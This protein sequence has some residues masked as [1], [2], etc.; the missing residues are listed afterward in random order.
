METAFNGLQARLQSITRN[1]IRLDPG[2]YS[3]Y[4]QQIGDALT[5]GIRRRLAGQP[6]NLAEHIRTSVPELR[7]TEQQFQRFAQ[8]IRQSFGDI[9]R[10]SGLTQTE[11]Q[12]KNLLNQY[13]Q[14]QRLQRQVSGTRAPVT[15]RGGERVW[16]SAELRSA[17]QQAGVSLP[18]GALGRGTAR[19]VGLAAVDARMREVAS[20]LER[21]GQQYTRS[22]GGSGRG[23]STAQTSSVERSGERLA[24]TL[25]KISDR[26]N[27]VL[28]T[29]SSTQQA[30]SRLQQSQARSSSQQSSARSSSRD[31]AVLRAANTLNITPAHINQARDNAQVRAEM[32]RTVREALGP[33]LT[34]RATTAQAAAAAGRSVGQG[35][36]IARALGGIEQIARANQSLARA[37]TDRNLGAT[38]AAREAR[39]AFREEMIRAG[40]DV[41][42][43]RTPVAPQ[44]MSPDWTRQFTQTMQELTNTARQQWANRQYRQELDAVGG[45]PFNVRT[46]PTEGL[47]PTNA[48]LT[49]QF[50]EQVVRSQERFNRQVQAE[51]AR[52]TSRL[53]AEGAGTWY[54]RFGR[55]FRGPESRTMAENFGQT[56][57]IATQYGIMYRVL[58]GLTN[59]ITNVTQ[60]FLGL[61]NAAADLSVSLNQDIGTDRIQDFVAEFSQLAAS[62][63]FSGATGVRTAAN[64]VGS[65]GVVNEDPAYA[66][67]A[68]RAATETAMRM[69]RASGVSDGTQMEGL[70]R[71]LVGLS[72]AFGVSDTNVAS[73]EDT[74]TVISRQGGASSVE[75]T[76]AVAS[77]G[78]LAEKAGFTMA[79]IAAFLNRAATTTGQTPQEVANSLKQ[80]LSQAGDA[81]AEKAMRAA[82]INTTGTTL[83]DQLF[84]LADA[85]VSDSTRRAVVSNFGRGGG[86]DQSLNA[87]L[88]DPN[89]IRALAES[90]QGEAAGGAGERAFQQA[91]STISRQLQQF[92]ASVVNLGSQLARTGILAPLGALLKLLQT[93]VDVATSAVAIFNQLPAPLRNGAFFV[94]EFVAAL[95]ILNM[96]M[97]TQL[98]ASTVS[99]VQR[100]GAATIAGNVA[101]AAM[102]RMTVAARAM[103]AAQG[104]GALSRARAGVTA[105]AG[106]E[107]LAAAR[108]ASAARAATAAGGSVAAAAAARQAAV[109][110]SLGAGASA[111]ARGAATAGAT[112]GVAA[113]G[114]IAAAA[115]PLVPIIIGA[116]AAAGMFAFIKS[117][118]EDYHEAS[119]ARQTSARKAVED[120]ELTSESAGTFRDELKN[121]E[122]TARKDDG[123][124][125]ARIQTGWMN[126]LMYLSMDDR[127]WATRGYDDPGRE[128]D[129]LRKSA[130]W[131]G[132][133]RVALEQYEQEQGR[134]ARRDPTRV[135]QF[136]T[137]QDVANSLA[138]L[139]D[140][141]YNASEQLGMLS[142]KFAE[143]SEEMRTATNTPFKIGQGEEEKLGLGVGQSWVS[144]FT[145]H[146]QVLA[147]QTKSSGDEGKA[148]KKEQEDLLKLP[149][150]FQSQL[151]DRASELARQ[152]NQRADGGRWTADMMNQY[153]REVASEARDLAKRSDIDL[154]PEMIRALERALMATARSDFSTQQFSAATLQARAANIA[155][156]AGTAGEERALRTGD[157]VQGAQ[158]TQAAVSSGLAQMSS[159]LPG[160]RESLRAS[161]QEVA[162]ARERAERAAQEARSRGDDPFKDSTYRSALEG[163]KDAKAS[164]DDASAE[165]EQASRVVRNFGLEVQRSADAVAEAR[166]ERIAN[167]SNL[168]AARLTDDDLL[169]KNRI[170]LSSLRRQR[171]LTR[172]VD[173]QLKLDAQIVEAQE[174]AQRLA[175]DQAAASRRSQLAPR[176]RG[177]R[178]QA[179]L[180]EAQER[181]GLMTSGTAAANDQITQIKDLQVQ[182]AEYGLNVAAAARNLAV[183]P[184][185]RL[186][187]MHADLATA[188][189]QA[190]FAAD[191]GD[192]LGLFEAQRRVQ[193]IQVQIAE[194]GLNV[195]AATRMLAVDPRNEG[196]RLAAE[197]ASAKDQL[198]FAAQGGDQLG[199]LEAQR[200]IQEIRVQM[201]EYGLR[202]ADAARRAARDPRDVLGSL[203]DDLAAARDQLRH[204]AQGGD[205]LGVLQAQRDINEIRQR[206]REEHTNRAIALRQASIAPGDDLSS[207]VAS[208]DIA[209]ERLRHTLAGTTEYYE[210]LR[211]LREAQ[212]NHAKTLRQY[213]AN[214]RMLNTDITDPVKVAQQELL[215][216]RIER[217]NAQSP[218]EA[219]NAQLEVQRSEAN[220]EQAAFQQ[221]ISDLQTNE[222][223]GRISHSTYMSYLQAE[224]QRLSAIA[225]RTRQQQDQLNEVEKLML[226]AADEMSGQFNIGNIKMPTVYEV[227]RAVG[228]M[229]AQA[230]AGQQYT[231]YNSTSNITLNGVDFAQVVEYLN[232]A[233]GGGVG[234]VIRRG[235]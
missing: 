77:I 62:Y 166:R 219:T 146:Q 182:I 15:T 195:A 64:A 42:R 38:G 40:G 14:L 200:R 48:A 1:L 49:R 203:N 47:S 130:S 73:I 120:V 154:S 21:L 204:A 220:L 235:Y 83:R 59:V 35:E 115:A 105:Y 140:Q 13:E 127:N 171:T 43:A 174:A 78:P 5:D 116:L 173:E 65:L 98:V 150:N 142:R 9:G 23:S 202:V 61:E 79:E 164:R 155:E 33:Q 183:D 25:D 102:A 20:S 92:S 29:L 133:Q 191:T 131:A 153:R 122:K 221:R 107:A 57:R 172:D 112:A 134:Q 32:T 230:N 160:A 113:G 10:A 156:L 121:L 139:N 87:L 37:A 12:L 163:L 96:T 17:A 227:R 168:S 60:D 118:V 159:T 137:A 24:Q 2:Q 114:A 41:S 223:L 75:L 81:N 162:S 189:A 228:Q 135:L 188:Q 94:L 50:N 158:A 111:A 109:T 234:T 144:A 143:V 186:G 39:A 201:A 141:G 31:G 126:R 152:Y 22:I 161:Q 85:N 185:N 68:V 197:L 231:S 63:G 104:T 66:N 11:Q 215:N 93:L 157:A 147:Q 217:A 214:H 84:A 207:A 8:T 110:S 226:A 128:A 3:R 99:L 192:Q 187:Q 190:S 70:S 175:V 46:R 206:Q 80:V 97:K 123:S 181:L 117:S 124:W 165:Y 67:A 18:Q 106:A 211:E 54:E 89:A 91:M 72:R 71:N 180:Q 56:A 233:L 55:G 136:S 194:Y 212:S 34:S 132:H 36:A 6:I 4:G 119:Q 209:R 169:G 16:S 179:D 28:S 76:Q 178:L 216:A 69:A 210:A 167:E 224:H 149:E 44:G 198:A 74:M 90:A 229:T 82:G 151:T 196:G 52:Q 95:H 58:T 86:A 19:D 27:R 7:Q 108:G 199:V 176:D 213:Q 145:S 103:A 177:A 184:R 53:S 222:Q 138:E 148:A 170:Q 232:S 26:L 225:N 208:I 205:Q 125:I 129:L 88:S 30:A 45:N 51:N 101:A 100:L 218:W 193:D